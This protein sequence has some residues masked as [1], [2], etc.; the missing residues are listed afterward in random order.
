MNPPWRS[1]GVVLLALV[2]LVGMGVPT[3]AFPAEQSGSATL[4]TDASAAQQTPTGNSS[5]VNVTVGQ[6]LS[7]IITVS[8]DEVQTEYEN[9]AFALAIE[10]GDDDERADALDDRAEELRERAEAIRDDYEEATEE[11]EE[12]DLTKSE[13]AQR[14]ATLNAR[15]TNLIESYEQFRAKAASLNTSNGTDPGFNESALNETIEDLESVNGAGVAALLRHFTGESE[16]EIEIET[17]NGL[18]IEV[19]NE[20]GERS[21]EFERPRDDDDSLTVNQSAALE[22][23]RAAL[24][25]VENGS[26][27]LTESEVDDDDGEYEFEFELRGASGLDGEAEVDVDGSS[28]EI[29]SLEEEIE[30]G[31]D[32]EGDDDRDDADDERDD[33]ED[34]DD[35]ADDDDEDDDADD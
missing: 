6:Q 23:A 4:A 34:E 35:E 32:E 13:Y 26:W 14:L 20:D 22:T 24:T 11:Y 1:I 10:I 8:S 7:T 25:P 15:A 12:G 5:E 3:T 29:F 18:E 2:A 33:D 19:E 31:D 16:G 27:E 30:A 28:G 21:R 17:A 9:T